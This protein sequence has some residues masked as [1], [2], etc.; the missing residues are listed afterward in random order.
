MSTEATSGPTDAG[1]D[2]IDAPML[3]VA[4]LASEPFADTREFMRR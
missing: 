4:I 2:E 1:Q 3:G